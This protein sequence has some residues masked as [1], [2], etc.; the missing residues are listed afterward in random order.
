M[1]KIRKRS[2]FAALLVSALLLA[3][4][5][6][7]AQSS[8]EPGFNL[9]S[10]EQEIEIGRES[11][12]EVESQLPLLNDRSVEAYVDAVGQR[13]AVEAP[14]GDYPYQFEVLNV[15]DVNAFALPGG[16]MYLNRG[17]VETV[18]N[19]SELAG[20]LAHEIAHVVEGHSAEQIGRVRTA[21]TGLLLASV[22]L[23]GLP[24]P[25]KPAIQVGGAAAFS[26]YS[27]DAEREADR[28]A[29]DLLVRAGI[30]PRGLVGFLEGML[31]MRSR[32]PSAVEQWFS[33]HPTM[34]SRVDE[35]RATVGRI[36]SSR[37]E[38]LQRDSREFRAIKRRV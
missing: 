16:F 10:V 5:M 22:L 13:L 34:D 9:F 2:G 18:R 32:R 21:N 24:D 37:L 14:H 31:E 30:D 15:A 23:G 1:R 4:A 19:E 20:V 7:A 35:V 3:P 12:R 33:T 36:P 27:R 28:V 8:V 38:G 11:A 26:A 6:L 25:A 29:V 17:L